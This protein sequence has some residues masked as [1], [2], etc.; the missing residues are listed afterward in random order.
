MN[1]PAASAQ[2]DNANGDSH[3]FARLFSGTFMV[4]S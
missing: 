2:V 4:Y 3:R 1:L